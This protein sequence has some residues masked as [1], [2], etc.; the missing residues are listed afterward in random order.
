M[1]KQCKTRLALGEIAW[2][3]FGDPHGKPLLFFHGWPGSSAQAWLLDAAARKHGFRGFALDRPGIGASPFCARCLLDWP[4]LVCAF[5]EELDLGPSAILG[6]SGGGPYALA[7]AARCPGNL[8]RVAVVCGAPPIADLEDVSGMHPGYRALLG[9]YQKHP[10]LVRRI[11][12]LARPVIRWESALAFF[13]PTRH[14]LPRADADVLADPDHFAG[15]FGC[16]R[17]AFEDVDGLFA[18]AA[19]YA[20]PWGFCPEEI[21]VPVQFW[22]GRE[23]G[24]FHYSMAVSL[25][26]R[27]PRAHLRLVDGEGHYSLPINHADRIVAAL[28]E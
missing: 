6:I 14:F 11:F 21:Q 1:L 19:I 18:D 27:I 9:I 26:A 28:A 23:D 10:E 16:Q 2:R 13:P 22:H 7:C 17:D 25:A 24:N 20:Q 5:I 4:P 15:V 3:A 12:R 8:T